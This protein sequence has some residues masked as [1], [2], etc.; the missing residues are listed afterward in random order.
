[1]F[2]SLWTLP[3][4]N[5]ELENDE[6]HVWLASINSVEVCE[7]EGIISIDESARAANFYSPEQKKEYLVSRGVLRNILARYTITPAHSLRFKY[8]EYGKPSLAGELNNRLNFNLSHSHGFAVISVTNDSEI[9]VDLEFIDTSQFCEE[10]A[11]RIFTDREFTHFGTLNAGEREVFFYN[12]WTRKE[13]FL[14]ALGSGLIIEPNEIETIKPASV[15]HWVQRN[16]HSR[17]TLEWSFFELDAIKN[18]SFNLAVEGINKTQIKY[19]TH[20]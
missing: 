13:A 16:N 20:N 14:K 4:E 3:P 6:V 10:T 18:F 2:D 12:C 15:S 1:M 19:W 5:L 8:N 17:K 7:F 9:G 11:R